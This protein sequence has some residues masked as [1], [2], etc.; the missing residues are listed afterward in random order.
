METIVNAAVPTPGKIAGL[1]GERIAAGSELP[2]NESE[3]AGASSR[4]TPGCLSLSAPLKPARAF[5]NPATL[6][7]VVTS[8][9][10]PPDPAPPCPFDGPLLPLAEI[11][12]VTVM[13]VDDAMTIAPPPP[14]PRSLNVPL[15]PEPPVIG[16]SE[17][18][19]IHLP[20]GSSEFPPPGPKPF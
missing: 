8:L 17:R 7:E 4:I 10:A 3:P 18:G 11:D 20:C 14:P 5:K 6:S 9:I 1:I 2:V 12:P 13:D 19:P 16:T 15:P